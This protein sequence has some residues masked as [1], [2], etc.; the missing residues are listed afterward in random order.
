MKSILLIGYNYAPEPTGIGK[1]TG[2]FGAYLVECGYDVHAI[3]GFPYYPFW[4][5]QPGYNPNWYKKEMV[6][7][8]HV[9]RCPMY[10][11]AKPSGLKRMIL[12][13]SFLLSAFFALVGTLI[14]RKRFDMVF[15]VSPS[16]LCGLL[17]NFYKLFHRSSTFVYHVQDLQIDAA[18][19]FGLVKNQRL[20]K[21]LRM[22]ENRV[23]RKADVVSTLTIEMQTRLARRGVKIKNPQLLPNWADSKQVAPQVPD[24]S[25]FTDIDIPPDSKILLYSGAMGEKQNSGLILR[26]AE[27]AAIHRPSWLFVISSSGPYF[28]ALSVAMAERGLTNARFIPLQPI[29]EF[30]KLLN[31]AW[32]H[33]VVQKCGCS[34]LVMPSKLTNI[35]AVGGLALVTSEPGST[36]SDM[37][38]H[39]HV[40]H[41][42]DCSNEQSFIS[43]LEY[44]D[45][46][47]QYCNQ[48]RANALQYANEWLLQ[49]RIIDR[50]MAAVDPAH[51]ESRTNWF[52][53]NRREIERRVN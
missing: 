13:A 6:D 9:L 45:E 33:L 37:V 36:L 50:F 5:V 12:D 3:T 49:D 25:W 46:H 41:P 23:L 32:L 34:D 11:P 48:L 1:Y 20:L 10:I 8:V 53:K 52:V 39:D 21:L 22:M 18:A 17:G 15:V 42:I 28:D 51:E 40:G 16:F 27:W 47:P 31:M 24:P 38:H 19:Q 29:A 7:G 2:E 44:L 35:L 30:N 26:A 43:A 14:T 4:K